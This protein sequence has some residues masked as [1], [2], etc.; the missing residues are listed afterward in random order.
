[1]VFIDYPFLVPVHGYPSHYY[2]AT[3]EGLARLFDDG[4]ERISLATRDNQT[5]D[6]ALSWQLNEL[7][8]AIGDPV[9]RDELLGLSVG[10]LAAE[11]PGGAMWRRV[12]A[13]LPHD[14]RARL[15]A[16][17]TLIARKV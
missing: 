16:G 2:N 7:V 3:R 13:S 6:H 1:M 9:L 11:P 4:F 17:N 10:T 12:I 8:R 5:P 15:G 14:A